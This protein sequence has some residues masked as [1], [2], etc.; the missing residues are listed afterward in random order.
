[1]NLTI[2]AVG[3]MKA[4]P[5]ADLYETYRK[6]FQSLGRHLGLSGIDDLSVKSGG[7]LIREGERLT[8]KL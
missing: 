6:R 1:M 8:G 5:E 4:G 2:L 3:Q 7:G